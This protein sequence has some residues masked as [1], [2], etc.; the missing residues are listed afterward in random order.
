MS[1]S[2]T[3]LTLTRT[4]TSR[5]AASMS[6][7][8]SASSASD[9]RAGRAQGKWVFV[10]RKKSVSRASFYSIVV[11]VSEWNSSRKCRSTSQTFR[12]SNTPQG[13]KTSRGRSGKQLGVEAAIPAAS[14]C[15]GGN[16]LKVNEWGG[17]RVRSQKLKV[18][19]V[20]VKWEEIL[21]LW[22]EWSEKWLTFV[23][24][25]NSLIYKLCK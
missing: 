16:R 20:S 5:T 21:K 24:V 15:N 22:H 19:C 17:E 6:L 14:G 23:P 18:S 13:R 25:Q 10:G 2:H 7:V 8:F 1:Y 4:K 12:C 3:P 9:E 11:E